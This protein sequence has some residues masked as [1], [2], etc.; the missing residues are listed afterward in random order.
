MLKMKSGMTAGEG[1]A[2]SL[3]LHNYMPLL[4]KK[5]KMAKPFRNVM[6]EIPGCDLMNLL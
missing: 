3:I 2:H 6:I 5:Y 1:I 4:Q